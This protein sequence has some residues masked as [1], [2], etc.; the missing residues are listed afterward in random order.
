M[1]RK[2]ITPVVRELRYLRKEVKLGLIEA[3]RAGYSPLFTKRALGEFADTMRHAI[4]E[5]YG[6]M[7]VSDFSSA[8]Q[9]SQDA[10][11]GIADIDELLGLVGALRGSHTQPNNPIYLAKVTGSIADKIEEVLA[12]D[13][14]RA[15]R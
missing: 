8:D 5:Y 13:K 12:H 4:D 14:N 11:Y 9:D 1:A 10:L 7:D 2:C 6:C 3:L 15:R